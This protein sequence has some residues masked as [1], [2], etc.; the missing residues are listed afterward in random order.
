MARPHP[1]WQAVRVELFSPWLTKMGKPNT[2]GHQ[3]VKR[4]ILRDI[5]RIRDVPYVPLPI[6]ET[7]H[8]GHFAPSRC[9]NAL[10]LENVPRCPVCP[11]KM[12]HGF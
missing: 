2:T 4:D 3:C 9:F 8:A 12:S 6:V 7:G 10:T 1:R 5:L 11:A